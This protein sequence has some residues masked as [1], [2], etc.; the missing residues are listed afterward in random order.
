M[1]PGQC[2]HLPRRL[3]VDLLSMP[4]IHHGPPVD[5]TPG[6]SSGL[7]MASTAMHVLECRDRDHLMPGR[8]NAG[9]CT[10]REMPPSPD[11]RV[12]KRDR[13]PFI[14]CAGQA[15]RGT[16]LAPP[17]SLQPPAKPIPAADGCALTAFIAAMRCLATFRP[18]CRHRSADR[19]QHNCDERRRAP[20]MMQRSAFSPGAT[21]KS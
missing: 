20:S 8:C 1:L 7:A 5:G 9:A 17:E 4:A 3:V 15:L 6:S 18:T 12:R 16:H 11:A 10:R 21:L 14:P 2:N 13:P 19:S